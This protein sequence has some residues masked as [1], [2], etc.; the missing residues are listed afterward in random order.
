LPYPLQQKLSCDLYEIEPDLWADIER[1][2]WKKDSI[3]HADTLAPKK[4]DSFLEKLYKR[5]LKMM[6]ASRKRD[7]IDLQSLE[8]IEE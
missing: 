6:L 1:T 3:M 8:I 4:D 7:S 5:K 2:I